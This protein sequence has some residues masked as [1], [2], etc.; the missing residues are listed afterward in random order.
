V[1][2]VPRILLPAL[3][4]F[5]ALTAS[6]S[7]DPSAWPFKQAGDSGRITYNQWDYEGDAYGKDIEGYDACVYTDPFDINVDN[8]P[9]YNVTGCTPVATPWVKVK[10]FHTS[11]WK[12]YCPGGAAYNWAA[13]GA[14]GGAEQFWRTSGD[15]HFNGFWTEHYHPGTADH[16]AFNASLHTHHYLFVIGCSPQAYDTQHEPYSNGQGPTGKPEGCCDSGAA[17]TRAGAAATGGA[18]MR[19]GPR[20]RRDRRA[21][22]YDE[23]REWPLRRRGRRTYVTRCARGYRASKPHWA[24][25]WFTRQPPRRR[26]DGRTAERIRPV[27]R[28][29]AV[30]VRSRGLRKG[31]VRLQTNLTCRR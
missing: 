15:L 16:A 6:A 29:F 26:R 10:P 19:K 31:A 30:T 27:K 24:V 23:T 4:S 17:A 21:R 28:G 5:L 8:Y 20:L 3:I 2:R 13:D 25:G 14:L 22:S 1:A 11:G 7:A 12:I 9:Q 18:R